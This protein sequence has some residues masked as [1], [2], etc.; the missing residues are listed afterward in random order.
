MS[1][2]CT[3]FARFDRFAEAIVPL[4][5]VFVHGGSQAVRLPE[6]FRFEGTEVF[7]RRVGD[8]VVLSA[9]PP[10]D[11][12]AL[13]DALHAFEPELRLQREQPDMQQLAHRA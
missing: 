6:E 5:K 13:L 2:L 3:Y 8:E 1:L 12:D 7:V 9:R 4:A 10:A 11:A